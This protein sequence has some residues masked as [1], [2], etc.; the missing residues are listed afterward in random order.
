MDFNSET[1][2]RLELHLQN[3]KLTKE[4][5]NEWL[6]P[7]VVLLSWILVDVLQATKGN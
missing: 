2:A 4:I 1:F 6:P 5:P 7:I 3:H